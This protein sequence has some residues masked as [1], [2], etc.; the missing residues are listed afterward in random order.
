[1]YALPPVTGNVFDLLDDR[2]TEDLVALYLQLKFDYALSPKSRSR[3]TQAFEYEL[4]Q[5]QTGERVLVQVKTGN[6][7]LNPMDYASQVAKVYLFSPAGYIQQGAA[8]VVCLEPSDLAAFLR[9]EGKFLTDSLN[10]RVAAW[11]RLE[12]TPVKT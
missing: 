10:H 2:D 7:K 1:M 5:R 9:A 12:N 8:R 11:R 4:V 6:I 3:D